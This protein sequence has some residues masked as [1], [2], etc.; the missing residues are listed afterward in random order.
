MKQH[1]K[2]F[3]NVIAHLGGSRSAALGA[4]VI[5]LLIF[6]AILAPQ[7]SPNNPIKTNLQDRLTQPCIEYPLGTDEYGRCV[8]SRLLY[9]SRI[10]LGIGFIVVIISGTIGIILGIASGYY[11]G[12]LDA[13]IMRL[14]DATMAFPSIFLALVIANIL[15]RGLV[16]VTIALIIIEWTKY[17]RVARG[18]VL[19]IKEKEFIE[20]ARSLG[21]FDHYIMMYHLIPN[22]IAPVI[23]IG[24]LGIAY[25]ILSVGTLGFLGFGPQ[26]PTP[27]WGAM[28]DAGRKYMR[29][30]PY[31]MIFPGLA[32]MITVLAFNLFGDGLRDILDPKQ[33][34]IE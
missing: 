29:T 32:I 5:I 17:A 34:L 10:S 8:L 23:V 20:S 3:T 22:I 1:N 12:L 4:V 25:V 28:L 26:P 6:I 24:T 13:V 27:E 15:G 7:L 14:V 31:L 16:S 33:E 2:Q 18:S 19:S 30:A 9:G 21:A 11:G